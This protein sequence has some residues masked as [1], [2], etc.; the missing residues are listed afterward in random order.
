MGGMGYA[1][2]E[3]RAPSAFSS[4]YSST[5]TTYPPI[6]SSSSTSGSLLLPHPY[7]R[8][9]IHVSSRLPNLTQLR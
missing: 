6:S 7:H 5:P 8:I 3:A 1:S 9:V 4:H 2:D